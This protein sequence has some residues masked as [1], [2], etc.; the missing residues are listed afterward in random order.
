MEYVNNSGVKM[1]TNYVIVMKK[2]A[3]FFSMCNVQKLLLLAHKILEIVGEWRNPT[4]RILKKKTKCGE[5]FVF[6][7]SR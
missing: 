4:N 7:C 1:K 3:S 2:E 6:S 5:L